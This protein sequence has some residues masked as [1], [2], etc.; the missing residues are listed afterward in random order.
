MV[1]KKLTGLAAGQT[2]KEDRNFTKLP[3]KGVLIKDVLLFK[4]AKIMP[5]LCFYETH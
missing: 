3:L 5:S 4:I 2:R 1:D